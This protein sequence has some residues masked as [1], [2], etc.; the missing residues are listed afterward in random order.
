MLDTGAPSFVNEEIADAHGG[1]VVIEMATMAAGGLVQW[2]P[3]QAFPSV[4]LGG[5]LKIDQLTA[6][7]GWS[8][9][10]PFYC[11]TPNG[12]IGSQA[13]R[14]AVWQIHYGNEEITVAADVS[15]LD[16]V[17]G[18][19]IP[20]NIKEGGLSPTPLVELE[21]GNGKLLF[22]VDTG[23]GVPMTL[24]TEAIAAIGLELPEDAP[25][26]A[27]KGSGASGDFDT[28]FSGMTVPVQLGDTEFQV[29][30]VVGDG[31]A[32]TT[33]G[34]MG[35]SFLRN[36]VVTLDWS[37]QM[38]YLDPLFEG[39]IV[40]APNAPSAGIAFDGET[41]TVSGVAVGGPADEAGLEVGEVVTMVDGRDV[42]GISRDDFCDI[43]HTQPETITTAS[44]ASFD[45]GIIEGFYQ[46][47][48]GE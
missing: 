32:P 46:G 10:G 45:V 22:I 30:A 14:N 4:T 34:N 3:V 18:I 6:N 1:D 31:L 16:H 5:A 39:N 37:S 25:V 11:I 24:N 38:M 26:S 36:F 33:D 41:V 7:V 17:D 21:V 47:A 8:S 2:S 28:A 12:L 9:T 19:Q 27:G 15:Q 20:F 13:M 29:T 43:K 35:D 40:P 42:A 23:G 48:S 44:G